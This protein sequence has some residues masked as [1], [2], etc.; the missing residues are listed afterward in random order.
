MATL[1]YLKKYGKIYKKRSKKK[2]ALNS[3]PQRKAVCLRVYI[4]PPK[5]P[6]SAKRKVAKVG[7]MN[8][9][10]IIAYIPGEGHNLQQYSMVLI[11]GGRVKDLPGIKYK[12][13]RGKL[14]LQNIVKRTQA[15]SK[16]GTKMWTTRIPRTRIQK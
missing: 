10:Q 11:R 16:Y 7:F 5:K 2:P 13:I 8:K 15:R 1:L 6:H 3:C 4:L 9:K 12:M 14:D